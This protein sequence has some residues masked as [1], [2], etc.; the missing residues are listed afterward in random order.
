MELDI[1]E[2]EFV[3]RPGAEWMSQNGFSS[4]A[5]ASSYTGLV[6]TYHDGDHEVRWH[7][8]CGNAVF[9]PRTHLRFCPALQRPSSD[10]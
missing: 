7:F 4:P 9:D 8:P 2:E 1:E 3:D 10:G 6:Q 5:K